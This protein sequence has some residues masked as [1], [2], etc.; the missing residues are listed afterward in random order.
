MEI[1]VHDKDDEDDSK[2]FKDV[3]VIIQN[4]SYSFCLV[5]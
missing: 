2:E 4:A 5:F 1:V 3:G